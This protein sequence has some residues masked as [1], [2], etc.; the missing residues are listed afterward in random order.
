LAADEDVLFELRGIGSWMV[1]T[2]QR[3][4]ISRDGSERRPR[5]GIQTFPI[6]N[7][8]HIRLERGTGPSGRIAIWVEGHEAVSMFFDARSI[9]QAHTAIDRLR[10]VL[11]RNRK[12]AEV[13]RGDSTERPSSVPPGRRRGRPGR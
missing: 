13:R 8:S 6:E 11:A 3:V 4:V 1:G 12:A 5:S 2:T 10:P 7:V 9:D